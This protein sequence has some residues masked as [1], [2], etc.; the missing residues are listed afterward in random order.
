MIPIALLAAA[1]C[2]PVE[3]DSILMSDLAKAVPAFASA[4]A[5]EAIGLAPAPKVRRTFLPPQLERLANAHGIELAAGTVA[6]FE[7][8]AE[9]LTEARILEALTKAAA[10]SKAAIGLIEFS[11]YPVPHG[12]LEFGPPPETEGS[13]P[14]L[15]RGRVT[16]GANRSVPVWARVKLEMPPREVERGQ[17]VAVEV[18]SGAALLKL[19]AAAESG[20]KTGE[21]VTVRNPGN[22]ARFRAR[23]T[24]KGKVTVDAN[25][26]AG[27]G[28]AGGRPDAGR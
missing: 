25:P 27:G 20:G 13:Q 21:L 4:P 17:T 11:R 26:V 8:A 12:Q 22:G 15:W 1:A 24:A 9:V 2:I 28:P 14:A 23:V 16:Y 10:G 5:T 6:C 19:D 18:R 7:G 3:G